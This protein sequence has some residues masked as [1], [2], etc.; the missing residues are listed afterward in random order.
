MFLNPTLLLV[1]L[2]ALAIPTLIHLQ[3]RRRRIR[4]T[5]SSLKLI[6]ECQSE[7]RR[8]RRITDWPI[9]LLRILAVGLLA[10]VFARPWISGIANNPFGTQQNIVFVLDRSASMQADGEVGPV[11]DEALAVI[12]KSLK[13]TSSES[14]VALIVTPKIQPENEFRWLKPAQLNQQLDTIESTLGTAK[15]NNAL[16]SAASALDRIDNQLPKVVHLV[17]D[18]QKSSVAYLDEVA[19][20]Q[21][22]AI[23]VTKV[24]DPN[25][26]NI[27]L[28]VA[29]TGKGELRSGVYVF[30][31]QTKPNSNGRLLV[32]DF[33]TDGNPVGEPAREKLGQKVVSRAYLGDQSGWYSRTLKLEL[34]D[35]EQE[36]ALKL[37]NEV[38]DSF[39]VERRVNVLLVEPR[40]DAKV[41]DQATFF[42][43]R[44]FDPFLGVSDRKNRPTRFI[45][46]TVGFE[47]AEKR[48]SSLPIKSSVLFLPPLKV[49]APR[50][51]AC[52]KQFIA[53]GGAAI[54]FAGEGVESQNYLQ[55]WGDLLPMQLGET[56]TFDSRVTLGHVGANHP[57][58][59]GLDDA[60][61]LRMFRL[62]FFQYLGGIAVDQ[63]RVLAKFSN[64]TPL[65]V[66]CQVGE[67]AVLFVN[68]SA[69]RSWSDWPTEAGSFVPTMHLLA[70]EALESSG[71]SRDANVQLT[72]APNLRPE[73]GDEFANQTVLINGLAVQSGDNGAIEFPELT[74]PAI[75]DVTTS[76]GNRIR[77]FAVNLDPGESNLE[78]LQGVV[79]QQQLQSQK[80]ELKLRQNPAIATQE[81]D[82]L[83]WK[84]LLAVLAFV[85]ALE[86]FLA[87]TQRVKS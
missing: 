8:P 17:A 65:V 55:Q 71:G 78:S 5:F 67:G 47:S 76:T 18:L 50:L 61:R 73:L 2:A 42:L 6:E 41:Y 31:G 43:S 86:P 7:S 4:V 22:V 25:P 72:Y 9:W 19:F 85:L 63:S 54:F 39:F 11:W 29:A 51:V 24:G 57:L 75:Y 36:D 32:Q 77:R 56:K 74:A 26:R 34:G 14:R 83:I 52:V 53:A 13:Q 49:M 80:K 28:S 20:S 30:Q 44:A 68:T 48:I 58:W 38:V 64:G 84:G 59:G 23:R 87:N 82:G 70:A 62:P 15:L 16:E 40:L 3:R 66:K 45:P 27:A 81:K 10:L 21:N 79:I 69:D 1:G 46:E 35:G 60:N 33:D 12:R 37:D